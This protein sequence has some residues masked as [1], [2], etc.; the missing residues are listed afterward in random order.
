MFCS[1]CGKKLNDAAKFCSG[2]GAAVSG[3]A[4][5]QPAPPQAA[6]PR[7]ASRRPAPP[8]P[9]DPPPLPAAGPVIV[10]W[11]LPPP[12]ATPPPRPAPVP[13]A[14]AAAPRVAPPPIG[15]V[16][17]PLPPSA[18]PSGPTLRDKGTGLAASLIARMNTW[19]FLT[20]KS[21]TPMLGRMVRGA[22]ADN[23]V[24]SEVA[25]AEPAKNETWLVMGIVIGLGVVGSLIL[26]LRGIPAQF[27][28][29]LIYM[30]LLQVAAWFARA[31]TVQVLGKAWLKQDLPFLRV[32]RPLVY[33]MTPAAAVGIIPGLGALLSLW[34]LATNIFA[35]RDTYRCQTG[36][37]VVLS[38]VGYVGALVAAAALTPLLG[39]VL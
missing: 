17:V 5:P 2:C 18:S 19:G 34:C 4:S 26:T 9:G 29:Q 36:Q 15:G 16:A 31:W 7:P 20:G 14:P 13:A 32:F 3:V 33:S 10:D 38:I 30:V 8:P 27:I 22:L 12:P 25:D 1:T 23:T 28:N 6:R 35:I 37:A 24:Y 21:Y 11:D 39:R